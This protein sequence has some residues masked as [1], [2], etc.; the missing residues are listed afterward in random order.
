MNLDDIEAEEQS[1]LARNKSK[2]KFSF[3]N[4][5]PKPER[6]ILPEDEYKGTDLRGFFIKYKRYFR[7][8]IYVNLLSV[9]GNF[10]LIFLI[11]ALSGL[12]KIDFTTPSSELF[13][14][15]HGVL[16]T[17][18]EITPSELI[19]FGINGIL[20]ETTALTAMSYVCFG[21]ATLTVFTFGC[22]NVGTTYV[23]RNMIKGEPIFI[24][25]DFKYAIKRNFKQAFWFGILD[26]IL[27]VLIPFNIIYL[28]FSA[29]GFYTTVLFYF[30]IIFSLIYLTMRFYIYLQMITFE[31]TI[32]KI[33]KNSLIFVVLG[34]KR[35]IMAF[36]G[37]VAMAVIDFFL[38]FGFGGM[39]VPLGIAI[40]FLVMFSNGAF[41]SAY[42]AY[43]KMKEIMIDPYYDEN[44]NPI[45]N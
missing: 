35:N 27:I 14:I 13:P 6:D 41:M 32:F 8:L 16:L 19:G 7:Q 39:L 40:P 45:S 31:L 4:R 26:A 21:I 33:L 34:F 15:F 1:E 44:G 30:T 10:P 12:F 23:I 5:K 2:K 25:S 20:T 37:I 11:I 17:S 18:S 24:W 38:I 28:Y 22:V 9:F 3:F 43:H 42:A 29:S 36:L